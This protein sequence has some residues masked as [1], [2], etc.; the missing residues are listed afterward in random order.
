MVHKQYRR[1]THRHCREFTRT[2]GELDIFTKSRTVFPCVCAGTDH[3]SVV[4]RCEQ[5]LVQD[6]T[7][8]EGGLGGRG[9][10]PPLHYFCIVVPYCST[11]V[12]SY[13]SVFFSVLSSFFSY[14]LLRWVGVLSKIVSLIFHLHSEV[15][16]C[17]PVPVPTCRYLGTR[18]L[19]YC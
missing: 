16:L 18:T 7:L 8:R 11:H 12:R 6:C 14:V 4:F 2:G 17:T 10:A 5:G 19:K 3:H 1:Q 13:R 9:R 15:L